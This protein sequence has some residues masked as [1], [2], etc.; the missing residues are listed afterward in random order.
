MLKPA[1]CAHS[2]LCHTVRV[3]SNSP[4]R[5]LHIP[6]RNIFRI[7]MLILHSMLHNLDQ[8][9]H[10]EAGTSSAPCVF[11]SIS[12]FLSTHTHT[13]GTNGSVRNIFGMFWN[14]YLISIHVWFARV[15]FLQPSATSPSNGKDVSR[16][17]QP[18][19]R[20]PPPL[21][22]AYPSRQCWGG[23]AIKSDTTACRPLATHVG[24]AFVGGRRQIVCRS[25]YRHRHGFPRFIPL[26]A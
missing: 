19:V 6:W 9:T 2:T 25:K 11:F 15:F 23:R 17:S 1:H 14:G 24:P 7:E 20:I 10:G 5:N 26:G 12:P 22:S 3:E 4:R 8:P 18:A 13:V 16:I 21:L